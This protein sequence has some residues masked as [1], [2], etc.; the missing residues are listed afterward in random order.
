MTDTPI[1]IHIP[2]NL[3]HFN[4]P[5]S[6]FKA[7]HPAY[8]SFAISTFI[9]S[10]NHTRL[11]LIQRA[12]TERAFPLKW[13]PPGGGIEPTDPTILHG[14]AR[15]AFEETGL[16]LTRFVRQLD[17]M[18][19]ETGRGNKWLKSCFEI[20]VA[21]MEGIRLHEDG[22]VGLEAIKVKLDPVEHGAF[23][24][25]SEEDVKEGRYDIMTKEMREV[26]LDSFATPKE[27]TVKPISNM[28]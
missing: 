24:W 20:Q 27:I 26:I 17:S 18:E 8:T 19:F 23:A 12:S 14:A 11:L 25:A 22:D 5:L 28:G 15:E 13:E 2:P 16:H 1:Q 6:T 10:P 4:V 9:F 3:S 21:E 7:N